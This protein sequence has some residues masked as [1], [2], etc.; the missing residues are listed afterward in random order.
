MTQ[1]NMFKV[2]IG[3]IPFS[4]FILCGWSIV[5]LLSAGGILDDSDTGDR[6]LRW[7]ICPK[8]KTTKKINIPPDVEQMAVNRYFTVIEG[9]K[10]TSYRYTTVLNG[11]FISGR[12]QQ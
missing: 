1:F 5:C 2:L 6:S 10:V 3:T 12:P 11:E 7:H 4:D 9:K 8:H